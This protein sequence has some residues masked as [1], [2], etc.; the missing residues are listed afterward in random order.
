MYL[1][2][3]LG[4]GVIDDGGAISVGVHRSC[5]VSSWSQLLLPPSFPTLYSS[6]YQVINLIFFLDRNLI[7][8]S[9][10]CMCLNWDFSVT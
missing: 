2:P 1:L 8:V 10:L 3:Q 6:I 7:S 5:G 9:S 4:V